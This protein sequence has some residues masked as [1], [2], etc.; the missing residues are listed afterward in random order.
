MFL[1]KFSVQ[2]D[3]RKTLIPVVNSFSVEKMNYC[4][5]LNGE[6]ELVLLVTALIISKGFMVEEL[7]KPTI[8]P[9][10]HIGLLPRQSRVTTGLCGLLRVLRGRVLLQSSS[11]PTHGAI[12][13]VT[14]TEK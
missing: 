5:S 6:E 14:E 12:S 10:V 8:S 3:N 13:V 2:W 1:A 9:S 11:A 7:H 4:S